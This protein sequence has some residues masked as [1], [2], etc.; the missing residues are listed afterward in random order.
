MAEKEFIA[1][2]NVDGEED[3]TIITA[4]DEDEARRR[5]YSHHSNLTDIHEIQ[6]SEA[7]LA[8]ICFRLLRSV[9]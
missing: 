3:Y 4:V 7:Y 2:Y 1:W 8:Y 6:E 9:L 5:F